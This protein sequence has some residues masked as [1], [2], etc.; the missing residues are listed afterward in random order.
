MRLDNRLAEGKAYAKALSLGRRERHEGVLQ[1]RPGK[2]G[3][4]VG[5]AEAR[6]LLSAEIMPARN[7]QRPTNQREAPS[8]SRPPQQD[9]AA[10]PK[11]RPGKGLDRSPEAVIEAARPWRKPAPANALPDRRTAE[12]RRRG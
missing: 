3:S 7:N 11:R 9:R 2:A 10:K 5:D 12:A 8:P 6:S 1:E 4:G